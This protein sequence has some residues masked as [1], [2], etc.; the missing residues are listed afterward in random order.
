MTAPVQV[1]ANIDREDQ[2]LGPLTARQ[3]VIIGSAAVAVYGLWQWLGPTHGAV[4]V[5]LSAPIALAATALAVGRRDGLGLDRL[6]L[7]AVRHRA[8]VR[9]A[10]NTVRAA[11]G[12]GT[13]RVV[14]TRVPVRGVRA[15]GPDRLGVVDLGAAGLAVVC[16]VAP[17][18]LS[19]RS[20]AEQYAAVAGFARWLHSLAGPVQLVTRTRRLDL[21]VPISRLR[22]AAP[23]LA[24]PA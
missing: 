20:A 10:P 9:S 18:N 2:L 3:L 5:V 17:A 21:S 15:V 22:A 11:A 7:A 4:F 14:S 23:G 6:L 16:S 1:P 12:D 8:Q 19:L 13:G 24:H